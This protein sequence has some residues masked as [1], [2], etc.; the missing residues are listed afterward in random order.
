V[1]AGVG[2]ILRVEILFGARIHPRRKVESLSDQEKRMVLQWVLRLFGKWMQ[3]M[4][5]KQTWIR[6][7]RRSG[8]PCPVCG[9]SIEFFRQAGRITYA[10]PQCQH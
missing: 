4:R 10:C 2:N 1:I 8:K 9:T 7:Y 3:Q 5:R 6:I